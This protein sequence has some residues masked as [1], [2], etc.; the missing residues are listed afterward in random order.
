MRNKKS[1]I[2]ILFAELICFLIT[3]IN[4]ISYTNYVYSIGINIVQF[5]YFLPFL[6]SSFYIFLSKHSNRSIVI[7]S[8]ASLIAYS[9]FLYFFIK[10]IIYFFTPVQGIVNFAEYTFK[11]YFICLPFMGFKTL[12]IKKEQN[13][14]KVLFLL[15]TKTILL[16]IITFIFK[17]LFSLKGVVYS[18]PLTELICLFIFFIKYKKAHFH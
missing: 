14:Q 8:T 16:L 18:W 17:N 13:L 10:Q 12:C 2:F 1:L 9:I 7:Y 5:L 6:I 3:R 4:L 15:F 11:I